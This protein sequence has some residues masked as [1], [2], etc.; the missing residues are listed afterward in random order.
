MASAARDIVAP[1]LEKV[2]RTV[3]NSFDRSGSFSFQSVSPTSTFHSPQSSFDAFRQSAKQLKPFDTK[4][5]KVLLLEN[6][7]QTGRDILKEQGYQ[8]EFYKSSLSEDEL[9]E[10]IR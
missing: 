8:V 7:N 1:K 3:S 10:K 2:T 4:D 9:V 6:V 5:I